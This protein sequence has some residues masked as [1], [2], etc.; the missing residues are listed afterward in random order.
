MLRAFTSEPAAWL[1]PCGDTSPLSEATSSE[2]TLDACSIPPSHAFVTAAV[3]RE[4]L[5]WCVAV[6]VGSTMVGAIP[7]TT[8][9]R[10]ELLAGCLASCAVLGSAALVSRSES[11]MP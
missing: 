10:D 1:G 9:T 6:T 2:F 3:L 7:L 8:F 4:G 11:V 5:N